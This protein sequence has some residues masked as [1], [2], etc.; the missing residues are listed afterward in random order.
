MRPFTIIIISVFIFSC[1]SNK[2]VLQENPPFEIE[3]ASFQKWFGGTSE[4][5]KGI[6]FTLIFSEIS[7]EVLIKKIYFRGKEEILKQNPQNPNEY[8]ATFVDKPKEDVVLDSN[9]VK[10]MD[11]S[12]PSLVSE[13]P[14]ELKANEAVI[15]YQKGTKT[16]YHKIENISEKDEVAYPSSKPDDN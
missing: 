3:A 14:F 8:R 6:H 1:N 5:G 13:I 16:F 10:E 15:Q 12:R 11:N 2:V 9:P 7:E 4:A